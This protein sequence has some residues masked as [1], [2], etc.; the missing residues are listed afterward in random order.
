MIYILYIFTPMPV[1]P[2]L[3]L[4]FFIYHSVS[5][6]IYLFVYLY[7]SI[8][9]FLSVFS[10][11]LSICLSVYLSLCPFIYLPTYLP[12]RKH[13]QHGELCMYTYARV[14]ADIP[15]DFTKN[16]IPLKL[17]GR[18]KS[19]FKSHDPGPTSAQPQRSVIPSRERVCS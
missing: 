7:I 3:S 2:S 1:C 14:Y 12:T 15:S 16:S 17:G 13:L 19:E 10:I 4:Y 8:S 9:L 6:S 5:I 18:E 11:H